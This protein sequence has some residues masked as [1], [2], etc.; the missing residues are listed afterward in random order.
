M[1]KHSLW[2]RLAQFMEEE[3]SQELRSVQ[4]DVKGFS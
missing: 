3:E 2:E 4:S 1:R